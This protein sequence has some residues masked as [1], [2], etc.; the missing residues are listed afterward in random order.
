MSAVL[1]MAQA[2][3]IGVVVPNTIQYIQKVFLTADG[4]NM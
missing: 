2:F 1:F 4:S 3:D